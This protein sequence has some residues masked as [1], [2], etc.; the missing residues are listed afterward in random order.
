MY[1][2]LFQCNKLK[3][4]QHLGCDGVIHWDNTSKYG[5]YTIVA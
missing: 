3:V 1:I 5:S 4:A 2:F